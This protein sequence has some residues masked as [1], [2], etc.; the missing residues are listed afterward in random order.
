MRR[1]ATHRGFTL[2]ELMVAI[3]VLALLATISWRALDGMLRTQQQV[4][5]QTD[6]NLTLQTVL[7]QWSSDWDALLALE[8]PIAW[9]GQLLRLTRSHPQLPGQGAMVVAWALRQEADGTHWLRW[10]SPPIHSRTQWQ[11]AW[12]NAALWAR[13]PSSEQRAQET[14]LLAL[15]NYKLFFHLNGAWANALSSADNALQAQTPGGL[16]S[17]AASIPQAVR[18]QITLS[19]QPGEGGN[20]LSGELSLIWV[21]PLLGGGKS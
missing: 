6:Q 17:A 12:D 11:Q 18:L 13:S 2:M 15:Q 21:N 16:S 20:A 1:P 5:Q 3:A 10:Q 7:A 14:R 9:D 4:R 19:Q 8:Q